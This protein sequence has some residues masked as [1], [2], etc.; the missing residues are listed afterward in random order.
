[1][2]G[3]ARQWAVARRGD[4]RENHTASGSD[5][6]PARAARREP[7]AA[8]EAAERYRSTYASQALSAD[9]RGIAEA[10]LAGV[11][12]AE[13]ERATPEAKPLYVPLV[14]TLWLT[15]QVAQQEADSLHC[16]FCGKGYPVEWET[17]YRPDGTGKLVGSGVCERC[18]VRL[19]AFVPVEHRGP[20]P[21]ES[22]IIRAAEGVTL[23]PGEYEVV[24]LSIQD[25]HPAHASGDRFKVAVR[26]PVHG[27][28][29]YWRAG[30]PGAFSLVTAVRR[31]SPVTQPEQMKPF[32]DMA[33]FNALTEGLIVGG[34]ETCGAEEM[35]MRL[36][37]YFN[38]T[39]APEQPPAPKRITSGDLEVGRWYRI[40]ELDPDD[41][42]P[43]HR[44]GDMFEL[45]AGDMRCK[46]FGTHHWHIYADNAGSTY[47]TAVE[48][49]DEPVV[50]QAAEAPDSPLGETPKQSVRISNL[51]AQNDNLRVNNAALRD[52]LDAAHSQ[53][54]EALNQRDEALARGD[55]FRGVVGELV[56]ECSKLR[57]E[58]AA[59]SK[60][61]EEGAR[62]RER[63]IL[64][65]GAEW[66]QSMN[67]YDWI[68]RE[69]T[70]ALGNVRAR[71]ESDGLDFDGSLEAAFGAGV[72]IGIAVMVREWHS[73]PTDPSPPDSDPTTGGVGER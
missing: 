71:Y 24:E 51:E 41:T 3:R 63:L 54:T 23:E 19:K 57:A 1:M 17:G 13:I 67:S 58:N 72:G 64:A 60:S 4:F 61:L 14:L 42:S 56:E 29:G 22:P 28:P 53:R 27:I 35:I 62:E 36:N 9:T 8:Q 21:P 33:S 46:D 25:A 31:V 45:K 2:A 37:A 7:E 49:V 32:L 30:A 44:V 65:R 16:M 59:L 34:N 5:G 10:F 40:L 43:V 47:V 52:L 12:W 15:K 50:Q 70:S 48:L 6:L 38:G 68:V 55:A 18:R 11:A 26:E 69:Q 66:P 39:T 73:K 20:A